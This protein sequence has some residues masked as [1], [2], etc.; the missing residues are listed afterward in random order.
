MRYSAEHK[1]QT[2]EKLLHSSGAIAKQGGFSA[3]G[4]DSL[5]KAIGLTGGA[6]YS[7]FASKNDLFSAIV[8]RELSHSL[9][10]LGEGD[11]A[12]RA[13]LQR[14]LERYLS[15][16]HVQQPDSGCAIP[17]LGAEI[18]RAD[19]KVREQAEHWLVRLQQA[20][21]EVLGS[22]EL[23]WAILAQ[24]VGAL[25]VARMLATE[26]RQAEVLEASKALLAATVG[27]APQGPE[28]DETQTAA[29]AIQTPQG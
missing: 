18:A 23:A 10:R 12:S 13:K 2:R 1:A 9:Q 24:C 22:G 20:W 3:A 6:F 11:D 15:M 8:E 19:L 5:M 27:R 25:V 16:A 14:C 21:S 26:Q 29:I 7:H 17:T 28:S 4:V